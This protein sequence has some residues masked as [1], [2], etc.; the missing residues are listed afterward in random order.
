MNTYEFEECP[1]R[2][3]EKGDAPLSEIFPR[4]IYGCGNQKAS[5]F[6]WRD[7]F[8]C[9]ETIVFCTVIFYAARNPDTASRAAFLS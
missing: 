7:E 3:M 1:D 5:T 8:S 6:L 4:A 9:V 2:G